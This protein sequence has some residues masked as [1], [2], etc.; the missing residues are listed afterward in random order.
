LKTG[1]F[2]YVHR[3]FSAKPKCGA[4][5]SV[6]ELASLRF[7]GKR[8]HEELINFLCASEIKPLNFDNLII[9]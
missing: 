4:V 9:S 2:V 5:V 8:A 1:C 6:A 3:D 7:A